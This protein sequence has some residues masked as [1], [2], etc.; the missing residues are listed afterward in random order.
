MNDIEFA[1]YMSMKGYSV[2]EK[3]GINMDS[4]FNDDLDPRPIN[5]KELEKAAKKEG[6]IYSQSLWVKKKNI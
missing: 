1:H 6:Y 3:E 5:Y 2:H 4:I